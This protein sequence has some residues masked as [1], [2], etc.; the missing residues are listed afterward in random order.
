MRTAPVLRGREWRTEVAKRPAAAD[1]RAGSP[2]AEPFGRF[3][4]APRGR[5]MP[6]PTPAVPASPAP[7]APP[8]GL[9]AA[10][11]AAA[12]A[13]AQAEV[14]GQAAGQAA[15]RAGGVV[16]GGP[17]SAA[18]IYRGFRAQREVLGEQLERLEDRRGELSRTL[19]ESGA[20]GA[21]RAGLEMRITEIDK[22]IANV[23]AQIA[24]ADAQVARAAALPGAAV[25]PPPPPRDPTE[26]YVEM[27]I[28]ASSLL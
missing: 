1:R 5:V 16:A 26:E 19:R 28:V 4:H 21:D 23:E 12:Q 10:I 3:Q 8:P 6:Q 25:E 13:A 27:G 7:P 17:G 24:A 11:Q 2:S 20:T 15:G 22:R 14:A 18:D 9:E